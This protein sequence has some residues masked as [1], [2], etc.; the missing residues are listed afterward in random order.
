[1][2]KTSSP[3]YINAS[4]PIHF[5]GAQ[6]SSLKYFVASSRRESRAVFVASTVL[7][8]SGIDEMAA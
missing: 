3:I 1:M 6:N 2:R 4:V 5:A 8:L 7:S